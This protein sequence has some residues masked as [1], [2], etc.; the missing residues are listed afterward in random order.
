MQGVTGT[1]EEW[2]LERVLPNPLNPRGELSE[3]DPDIVALSE[4]IKQRGLLEPILVT[5]PG[6]CVGGHRRRLACKL[7]GVKVVRVIVQSLDE[8]DQ[9]G[10]MLAE[11]LNRQDLNP[12]QE[13]R[14]YRELRTRG[15]LNTE[16]A[17][18]AGVNTVRVGER[19]KILGLPEDVQ[20]LFR[21][22]LPVSAANW[23]ARIEDPD[24]CRKVA[25]LV[26]S[27]RLSV[28][29]LESFVK[30][31]ADFGELRKGGRPPKAK[32]EPGPPAEPVLRRQVM[33]A[34]KGDSGRSITVGEL[35]REMAGVCCGCGL[36]DSE[37]GERTMCRQ[38]P[39]IELMNRFMR[40]GVRDSLGELA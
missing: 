23:L 25:Q 27:R 39:M 16:I 26:V 32:K 36:G 4:D 14:G 37:E 3:D 17:R 34:M 24:K 22:A 35:A 18:L 8:A 10:T 15:Y 6:F 29:A 11:N 13:A 9:I 21:E 12:L 30:K 7:A 33:A 40:V 19:L 31:G 2:P 20:A 38:C 1:V 5:P 28:P